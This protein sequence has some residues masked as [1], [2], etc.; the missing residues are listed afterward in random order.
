[1]WRPIATKSL[2][3]WDNEIRRVP[4][5]AKYATLSPEHDEDY[6]RAQIAHR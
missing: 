4:E 1:L 3:V 6:L 5:P 2:V